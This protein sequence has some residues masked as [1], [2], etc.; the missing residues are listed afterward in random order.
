VIELRGRPFT[1]RIISDLPEAAPALID[2]PFLCAASRRVR[3]AE[4]AEGARMASMVCQTGASL[5]GCSDI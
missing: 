3:N 5:N 1:F 2:H 4:K